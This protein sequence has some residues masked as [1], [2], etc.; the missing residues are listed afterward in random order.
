MTEWDCG[1]R[2]AACAVYSLMTELVTCDVHVPVRVYV[3]GMCARTHRS[4]PPPPP[5][6][7]FPALP[8]RVGI[9]LFNPSGGGV[10]EC[11]DEYSDG[12]ELCMCVEKGKGGG[13]VGVGARGWGWRERVCGK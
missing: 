9:L 1:E 4:V 10:Y 13:G 11:V 7:P 8:N 6:P 3:C 5:P 2:S 12:R